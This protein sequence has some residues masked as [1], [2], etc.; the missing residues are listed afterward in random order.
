MTDAPKLPESMTIQGTALVS[1]T[2]AR[3]HGFWLRA[4]GV[5]DLAK[6]DPIHMV[7]DHNGSISAIAGTAKMTGTRTWTKTSKR[8]VLGT[9]P[10]ETEEF[11]EKVAALDFSAMLQPPHEGYPTVARHIMAMQADGR[12]PNVSVSITASD[13]SY[14]EAE[15]RIYF[16][17]PYGLRHIGVVDA[18]AFNPKDGVG[19]WKAEFSANAESAV[20]GIW[21]ANPEKLTE[22]RVANLTVHVANGTELIAN[23]VEKHLDNPD[24]LEKVGKMLGADKA[25]PRK[26][27]PT[28]PTQAT[29]GSS[30]SFTVTAT[31]VTDTSSQL[32]Q[33]Q[34]ETSG[35]DHL[36]NTPPEGVAPGVSPPAPD[37]TRMS[38]P[39]APGTP[40]APPAPADP[41]AAKLAELETLRGQLASEVAA[42]KKQRED[43]EAA[44][45]AALRN[46]IK[47]EH[48]LKDETLAAFSSKAQLASLKATLDEK[49]ATGNPAPRQPQAQAGQGTVVVPTI[50][51][52]LGEAVA[53]Y[54]IRGA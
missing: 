46:S 1:N 3:G 17:P 32:T 52:A 25:I 41:V 15:D 48:G 26:A 4:Q 27:K 53:K 54:G 5:L 36:L 42:A 24:L 38:N 40:P 22:L 13:F 19:I 51:A 44:E 45:L 23:F 21:F 28:D 47:A 50:G 7:A 12:V 31:P 8:Y 43:A 49:T 34:A 9:K 11:T 14:D 37:V 35:D 18:G 39:P 20:R 30:A 10:R 6:H 33:I 2:E 29:T 16:E